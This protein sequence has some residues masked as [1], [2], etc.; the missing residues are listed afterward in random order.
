MKGFLKNFIIP[1][2]E[3]RILTGIVAF[4]A[5][6]IL[7][8]WVAINEPA[9]MAA[10]EDQHLGRSIERGAELFAANC[11]TCHGPNGLGSAERAPGLNNPHLFG[12]DY[13]ALVNADVSSYERQIDDLNDQLGD[14]LGVESGEDAREGERNELFAEIATLDRNTDEGAARAVEIAERIEEIN[15]LTDTNNEAL[16]AQYQ[17]LASQLESEDLTDDER[18]DIQEQ[19]NALLSQNIPLHISVLESDL[20]PLYT[21]RSEELA[22]L[23]PAFIAGYLPGLQDAMA[24]GDE[25]AVSAILQEHTSRLAQNGFGGDL[26]SYITT[27]LIHGRPG[28]QYIWGNSQMVAW[29]QRGGGPLRDDEIEDIRNYILN[30]DRGDEWTLEDLYA[31]QQFGKLPGGTGAGGGEDVTRLA[32]DPYNSDVVTITEALADVEGDAER[33]EAIYTGSALTEVGSRLGCGSCHIGGAAAPNTTD[34]WESIHSDI[35]NQ[36]QFAGYTAEQYI[37]ESIIYPNAYIVEGWTAGAMPQDF[38]QQLSLQDMADII[39][40][41]ASYGE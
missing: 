10:F 8:G 34:Q 19:I 23:E 35:L 12:Y 31:V 38:D 33:G 9:R 28:S 3:G 13:L 17:D 16:Q 26:G 29:S 40:Y 21:E 5:L 41:I 15:A 36:S 6:M 22:A 32:D 20:E 14:L 30:W 18:A 11:S 24:S 2:L 27:T 37:V 39:A 1:T 25:R 7:L 4:V